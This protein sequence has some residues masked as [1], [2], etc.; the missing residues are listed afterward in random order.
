M[1]YAALLKPPPFSNSKVG[2][3]EQLLQDFAEYVKTFE[4]FMLATGV[5]GNH[6]D[7][8]AECGGCQKAKATLDLVGGE[9][10]DGAV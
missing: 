9:G 10:D 4:K 3:P 2:D 8:H 7:G 6:T 1:E 5:A